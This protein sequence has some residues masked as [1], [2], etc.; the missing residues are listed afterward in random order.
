M[1]RCHWKT[2]RK[3]TYIEEGAAGPMD[4]TVAF[5]RAGPSVATIWWPP[6]AVRTVICA[7]MYW[8]GHSVLAGVSLLSFPDPYHGVHA[9]VTMAT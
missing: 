4:S 3:W 2:R 7:L 5:R 9:H 1:S 6:M 8:N